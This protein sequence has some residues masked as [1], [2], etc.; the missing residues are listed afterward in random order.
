MLEVERRRPPMKKSIQ[1]V[2]SVQNSL[3]NLC[4]PHLVPHTVLCRPHRPNLA[5]SPELSG[6]LE[7]HFKILFS[8]PE[9]RLIVDDVRPYVRQA[10]LDQWGKVRRA[11]GG[12]AIQSAAAMSKADTSGIRRRDTSF[13]RVSLIPFPPKSL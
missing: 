7:T 4:S 5:L 8:T 12:D 1:I 11:F 6:K 3:K 2:R 9:N 13:V 10:V